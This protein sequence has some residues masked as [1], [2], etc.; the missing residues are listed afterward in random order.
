MA[1]TFIDLGLPSGTLWATE[2]AAVNGKTFFNYVQA[3][4]AFGENNIPTESNWKELLNN[5]SFSWDENRKGYLFTGANKN[6]LFIP[7]TGDFNK[8]TNIEKCAYYMAREEKQRGNSNYKD[9]W[10]YADC[11]DLYPDPYEGELI[12]AFFFDIKNTPNIGCFY[13]SPLSVRLCKPA[14]AQ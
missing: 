14:G 7:A 4:D 8:L 10:D 6:T 5:C 13:I 1:L 3:C 9:S 2:N 11:F 12:H